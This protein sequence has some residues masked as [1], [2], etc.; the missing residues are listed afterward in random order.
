MKNGTCDPNNEIRRCEVH[1]DQIWSKSSL[2]SKENISMLF[3]RDWRG[4]RGLENQE[5][6]VGANNYYSVVVIM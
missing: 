6:T 2:K 1:H 5:T 3:F 4:P